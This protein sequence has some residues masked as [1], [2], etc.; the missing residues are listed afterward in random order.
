MGR[1][2][3]GS[4]SVE[5]STDELDPTQLVNELVKIV[6]DAVKCARM[7]REIR[8]LLSKRYKIYEYSSNDYISYTINVGDTK[9]KKVELEPHIHCEDS[10]NT[11]IYITISIYGDESKICFQLK[12]GNERCYRIND[13]DVE[14]IIELYCNLSGLKERIREY[15]DNKLANLPKTLE[16]LKKVVAELDILTK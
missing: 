13:I 15:L 12:S 10:N 2:K 6:D 7:E 1:S 16:F 5:V 9:L 4:K 11:M 14:D 8:S 3:S